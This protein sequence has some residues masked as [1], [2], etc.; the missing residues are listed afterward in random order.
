MI[1]TTKHNNKI[2]ST[3]SKY[4]IELSIN[5]IVGGTDTIKQIYNNNLLEFLNQF[6]YLIP[7]ENDNKIYYVNKDR[8]PLFYYYQDEENGYVYINYERIWVFFSKVI[9]LEYKEI[10]GIIKNWLDEVYNL[11]GL[12][13]A[14][15]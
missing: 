15:R 7:V 9:G 2:K 8:L 1:N 12:T 10:Q 3:I 14:S 11:S 5:M 4:G 6:N 13:P